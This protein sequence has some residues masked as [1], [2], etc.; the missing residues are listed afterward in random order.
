[1]PE[2]T[3]LPERARDWVLGSVPGSVRLKRAERLPGGQSGHTHLVE[4]ERRDQPPLELVLKRLTQPEFT[5]RPAIA[6]EVDALS[7]LAGHDLGVGVPEVVAHDLV[8]S[9]CDLPALL[10]TRVPGRIVLA[11]TDSRP[12]VAALGRALARF[13]GARVP[14]PE[15][16]EAYAIGFHRRQKPVPAGIAAPDWSRVWR[17]LESRAWSGDRLIHGDFHIGNT[18]FEGQELTGIVDWALARRGAHEL[19][20]SYC[21]LDLS[22]LMGGDASAVFS[23]AYAD[24]LGEE[25]PGLALWDL[26]ASVRTCPDPV[27][28]LP[29]WFDAGRSDLTP[30]LIQSRLCEFVAGALASV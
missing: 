18:V 11:A 5:E 23:A 19:D 9:I 8:G 4:L 29:G 2:N 3:V 26:A 30:A 12:R 6:I 17:I 13:H 7:A 20:V 24:E 22:L 27:E 21:R 15:P 25:L 1:M 14:C 28:W 16:L 10:M